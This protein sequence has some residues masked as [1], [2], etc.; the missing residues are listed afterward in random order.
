[1]GLFFFFE[2]NKR[3]RKKKNCFLPNSERGGGG[4]V[5]ENVRV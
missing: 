3:G 1:L 5:T 2:I 4:I